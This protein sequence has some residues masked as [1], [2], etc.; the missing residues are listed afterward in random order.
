MA[1][2]VARE[3]PY[4]M[5]VDTYGF[6]IVLWQMLTCKVPFEH[7]NMK[8]FREKV[9]RGEKKRPAIDDS[10]STPIKLLLKRGWSDNISE[11][12]TMENVVKI[13]KKECTRVRG[14]ESDGL[15][16]LKRRSTYVFRPTKA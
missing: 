9:H 11:R 8:H 15:E 14:G 1:P 12:H 13:L 16:H 3:E 4:N 10:W 5:T 7:Y 6:C 2:E